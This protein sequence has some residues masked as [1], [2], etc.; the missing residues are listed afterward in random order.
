[1]EATR[2]VVLDEIVEKAHAEQDGRTSD[3]KRAIVAGLRAH[4][5]P[6]VRGLLDDFTANGA[7]KLYGDW[8]RRQTILGRTKTGAAVDLPRFGA[9]TETDAEGRLEYRQLALEL[10]DLDQ[11]RERRNRLRGARNT[12]SREVAFL[13]RIVKAMEADPSL[14]TAGEA[15]RNLILADEAERGA[16]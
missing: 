3:V 8:R 12:M 14:P 6:W 7:A 15:L 10:L 11:L 5:A 13:D 1:M 4:R 2:R 9:V 16:A